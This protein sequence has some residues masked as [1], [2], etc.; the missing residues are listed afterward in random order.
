[1]SAALIEPPVSTDEA[2]SVERIIFGWWNTSLSPVGNDRADEAHKNIAGEIVKSLINDLKVDC[3]ALGEVTDSDLAFLREY[4]GNKKFV[5]YDGT[6]KQGKLQFDTGLIYD[7]ERLSI[8]DEK[9]IISTHAGRNLKVANRIDF[10]SSSDDSLFHVFV[11]HWP[12]RGQHENIL[13]RETIAERLNDQVKAIHEQSVNASIILI[14]DYN[15]DPFDKSLSWHFPATRDRQLAVKKRLFYNPFWRQLG[16]SE[17]HTFNNSKK[18]AGGSY[19]YRSGAITRWHTFDQ[20]LFSPAFLG[21]SDWHLN[22]EDTM[23]VRT[24]YLI[25]LV[26][27]D[28]VSFDHLPVLSVIEREINKK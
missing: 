27:N 17:P 22:E 16:E 20:I 12:S 26:Q 14:G 10:L 3:L 15:D 8:I 24:E 19:F 2:I 23:I 6:L 9:S 11:S 21:G 28:A 4:S 18:S 5:S 25:E 13:S 7:S 1:M